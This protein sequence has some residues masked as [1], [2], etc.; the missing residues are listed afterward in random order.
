MVQCVDR[1]V[2]AD[3]AD[4]D[5]VSVC[6]APPQVRVAIVRA[7]IQDRHLIHLD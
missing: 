6:R 4:D 7:T 1:Y 5:D 2:S 3:A